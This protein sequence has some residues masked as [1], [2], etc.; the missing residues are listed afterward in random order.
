MIWELKENLD[1]IEDNNDI[2]SECVLK[3]NLSKVPTCEI[4]NLRNR[5]NFYLA[6]FTILAKTTNSEVSERRISQLK[7][8]NMILDNEIQYRQ[9]KI[10]I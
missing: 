9:N 2:Y 8:L 4:Q 1:I 5:I 6:H 3:E 7:K 10:Y